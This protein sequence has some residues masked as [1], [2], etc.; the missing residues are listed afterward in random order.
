METLL[1]FWTYRHKLSLPSLEQYL[2]NRGS[3]YR[4]LLMGKSNA[5]MAR[6]WES[7]HG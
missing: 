4:L 5:N 2:L 3:V 6:A 1:G 7:L